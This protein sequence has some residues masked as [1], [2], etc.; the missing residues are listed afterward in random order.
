MRR[1]QAF[2]FAGAALAIVLVNTARAGES[3][4]TAGVCGVLCLGDEALGTPGAIRD[5][6][7]KRRSDEARQTTASMEAAIVDATKAVE[8]HWKAIHEDLARLRAADA[9]AMDGYA[10]HQSWVRALRIVAATA[11]LV[12]VVGRTVKAHQ[13]EGAAKETS[14]ARAL[15]EVLDAGADV[16]EALSS[17][18]VLEVEDEEGEGYL[19]GIRLEGESDFDAVGEHIEKTVEGSRCGVGE[20]RSLAFVET[21][22]DVAMVATSARDVYNA[23]KP[24]STTSTSERVLSGAALGLDVL[25][26][27]LP[28]VPAVGGRSIMQ[29]ARFNTTVRNKFPK[30]FVGKF[31]DKFDNVNQSGVKWTD[32][33]SNHNWVRIMFGNPKSMYPNSRHTYVRVQRRGK[34]LDRYGHELPSVDVDDAHIPIVDFLE[35]FPD[36]EIW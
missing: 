16:T 26:V 17:G 19:V 33:K 2:A 7:R 25:A 30:R 24:G 8:K 11:N 31:T 15:A 21:G 18:A 12:A 14:K 3:S 35:Y 34:A 20:C 1:W 22:F 10:D 5:L 27:A 23:F 32:P 9:R 29:I 36:E 4:V 28:G 6:D 13:A